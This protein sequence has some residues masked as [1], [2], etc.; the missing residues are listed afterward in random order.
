MVRSSSVPGMTAQGFARAAAQQFSGYAARFEVAAEHFDAVRYLGRA[1]TREQYEAV[2]EL[3]EA[4]DRAPSPLVAGAAGTGAGA[5]AA[6]LMRSS[7][8]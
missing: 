4:I 5:G 6:D 2:R 1:G 3:D 8:R 7:A